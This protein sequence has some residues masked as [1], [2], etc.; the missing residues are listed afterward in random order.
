MAKQES[1]MAFYDMDDLGY[2]EFWSSS[3]DRGNFVQVSD[4]DYRNIVRL[5]HDDLEI[6]IEFLNGV[7][8]SME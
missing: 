1:G 4:D 2:V 5:D 3:T 6:L 8:E 7:K